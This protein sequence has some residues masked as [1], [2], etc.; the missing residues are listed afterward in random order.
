MVEE[1]RAWA[2]PWGFRP[3]DVG[4]SVDLWYGQEDRLAPPS[5]RE[6]L[7]R[8]LPTAELH[9]VNTAGHLVAYDRR[10]EVLERLKPHAASK[11][12]HQSVDY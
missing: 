4:I 12:G 9:V 11:P 3:E 10:Q 1:Y 8:R 2:R 7:A 6:R 5:W